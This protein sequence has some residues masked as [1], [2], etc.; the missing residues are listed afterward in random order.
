MDVADYKYHSIVARLIR[1]LD[2]NY[3]DSKVHD[4]IPRWL[5]VRF[6]REVSA[7]ITDELKDADAIQWTEDKFM[8]MDALI[9]VPEDAHRKMVEREIDGKRVC[10][11]IHVLD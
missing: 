3:M 8:P 10:V 4:M 1:V 9:C 2:T 7:V 5:H 6:H 11:T